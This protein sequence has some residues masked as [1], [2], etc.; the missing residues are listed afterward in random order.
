VVGGVLI[1]FAFWPS[2]ES[3]LW[4]RIII[5]GA[6]LLSAVISVLAQKYRWLLAFIIAAIFYNP[7]SPIMIRGFLHSLVS[8]STAIL[9]FLSIP[10]NRNNVAIIKK[11]LSLNTW[12]IA[13]ASLTW[14][15]FIVRDSLAE[16]PL[17][18]ILFF[19]FWSILICFMCY[20]GLQKAYIHHTE[21]IKYAYEHIGTQGSPLLRHLLYLLIFALAWLLLFYGRPTADEYGIINHGSPMT[22]LAIQYFGYIEY[23]SGFEDFKYLSWMHCIAFYFISY[24]PVFIVGI[25]GLLLWNMPEREES[26]NRVCDNFHNIDG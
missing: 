4:I 2:N 8:V 6:S 9:F 21:K 13:I 7:I 12:I 24:L 25:G 17:L 22:A 11:F 14:F 26:P 18:S 3:S 20:K 16:Q 15:L 23:H 1:A 5:L 19:I 10:L